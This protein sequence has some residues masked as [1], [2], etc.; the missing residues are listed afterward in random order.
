MS[1]FTKLNIK[2]VPIE[3]AHGG[4]GARQVLVRPE[5]IT[6]QYLEAITKGF[7][8]P[9]SVFDWHI[10]QDTDEVFIVLKGY[11]KYY[12]EEETTNYK[13]GD[14]LVTPANLKHKIAAGGEEGSEYYFIRVKAKLSI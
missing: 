10:H 13:E 1:K 8:K 9:G 3:E 14:V 11:G 4:S 12:C 6:S 2:D 5:H 7:L